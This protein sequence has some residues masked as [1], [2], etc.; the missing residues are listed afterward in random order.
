LPQI[1]APILIIQAE[2]DEFVP[3]NSS[4]QI[5]ESVSSTD[6]SIKWFDSDHAIIFAKIKLDLFANIVEF[7]KKL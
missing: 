5:Y 1:I 2:H 3:K 7:I 6:K 4:S